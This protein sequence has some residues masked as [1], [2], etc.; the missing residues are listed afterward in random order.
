MFIIMCGLPQSGKSTFLEFV[1]NAFEHFNATSIDIIRPSDYYPPDIESMPPNERTE[2]QIGAWELALER[3]SLSL[4]G[5]PFVA[6]DTCGTSPNSLQTPIGVAQIHRHE[7]VVI[8]MAASRRVCEARIDPGIITKYVDKIPAAMR[9]YK[10]RGYKIFIVKDGTFDNW[11]QRA[12][13]IAGAI[14]VR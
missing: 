12:H 1:A 14:K 13:I 7:I 11:N 8:W 10:A 9:E 2:Y 6:L 3:A 5:M 4:S